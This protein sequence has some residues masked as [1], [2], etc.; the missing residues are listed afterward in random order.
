M[1]QINKQHIACTAKTIWIEYYYAQITCQKLFLLFT[2]FQNPKQ[3]SVLISPQSVLCGI[4]KKNYIKYLI[5]LLCVTFQF[6][7]LTLYYPVALVLIYFI[8][9]FK[10]VN[11]WNPLPHFKVLS[12]TVVSACC[13]CFVFLL[14]KKPSHHVK[15]CKIG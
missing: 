15:L 13:Y 11:L 7:S 2:A 10:R 6:Y 1:Q 9:F 8:H 14:Q 5:I 12:I 3:F 4:I